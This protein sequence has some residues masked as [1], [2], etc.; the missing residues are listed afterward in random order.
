MADEITVLIADDH[1]IF[2][3]GLAAL[4]ERENGITIVADAD[5]G[6]DALRLIEHHQPTVAVLD[7]D[8][9]EMDGFEIARAVNAASLPVRVVILSMHKDERHFN[10]AIESG[11]AGYVV[12]DGASAEVVGCIRTVAKGREY[13]SPELSSYLLKRVRKNSDANGPTLDVLTPTERKVL[14]HLADLKTSREIAA[15]LGISPRTVENHRAHICSK[16][17]LQG[18]HALTRFAIEH[19]ADLA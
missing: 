11:V 18:S 9:P 19:I 6:L 14:R 2:R 7:L 5:N 16:L 13:F 15:D 3:S 8:M 4:I 12:K 10:K 1:P 17:E